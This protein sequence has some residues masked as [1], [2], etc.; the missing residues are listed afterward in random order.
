[1]SPRPRLFGSLAAVALL[2]AALVSPSASAT[3]K[4][5]GWVRVQF[6]RRIVAAD[7]PALEAA[8]LEATQY[9][10]HHAYLAFGGPGAVDRAEELDGVRSVAPLRAEQKMDTVLPDAGMVAAEVL[11]YP[12][13]ADGLARR[14]AAA[15]LLA[16]R[17]SS[18]GLETLV[19]R[20]P[21]D[22]L[23]SVAADPAVQHVGPAALGFFAE[24]EGTDQI[25]AGNM[26]GGRPVPG[27]EP[28]LAQRGIDGEG[29]IVT[30]ADTG[31]DEGHPE[32]Q[33]RIVKEFFG[34]E[35]DPGGHGTHVAGIVGGRGAMLPTVG[36]AE[37]NESLLLGLGVAPKV[38]FIDEAL[39]G[40]AAPD[41]PPNEW[42]SLTRLSSREGSIGWNASW[43][44][45]GAAGAGYVPRARALDFVVRDADAER[46]GNQPFAMMFS[47]GN[48]GPNPRTITQPKEAKN[49]ITVASSH[50]HRVIPASS[51][52]IDTV[53]SFSSR[54]PGR[55]GRILPNVAAPG[56]DVASAM[57]FGFVCGSAG[58]AI[59]FTMGFGR[60]VNCSGTS[61][62]AP[63]VTGA[64]VLIHDWWR[65]RNGGADPSP[66]MAKAL[67]VN[68]ATD[69]G[70]ADI[71]NGNE[72]WG[73]VNLGT[74]FDPGTERVF[75]D[76]SVVFT[77]R[78]QL[79]GVDI[80]AADPSKP[81]RVTV[82]WTDAPGAAGA[83]PALVNDLD[84]RVIAPD[85]SV[86]L[87]NV[88]AGG[89]SVTGGTADRLNNVENVFL[90][91]AGSGTY[92]V[93]VAAWNVPGDGIPGDAQPTD[94]DFALVISNAKVVPSG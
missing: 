27:Y 74:L 52:G 12:G 40:G 6:D 30:I 45:G 31:M 69:M 46:A 42:E 65:N 56:Q 34:E 84:L 11:V 55:D 32:L 82:A 78:D 43:N 20:G 71:P 18:H 48:S 8:G 24:D 63:H 93:D 72:G 14:V 29:V 51:T 39:I 10:P 60:Y 76:Q 92:G 75:V 7:R 4:Q 35:G 15:G 37:D 58:D 79:H 3:A 28:F 85:G 17:F 61:M 23:R 88:F 59:T 22:A 2:S 87:G 83:R 5:P 41:F 9:V 57:A 81:L 50:S 36:R 62:A 67:L 1:M 73:R 25:L 38:S 33:G 21:A 13:L 16:G 90:K 47:A 94:Q 70:P 49:I 19:V 68:S 26:S 44:T 64:V 54:G 80:T 86:Y 91:Q 66:A 77:A 89:T 53:S